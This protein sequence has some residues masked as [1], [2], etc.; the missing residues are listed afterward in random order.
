MRPSPFPPRARRPDS[1]RRSLSDARRDN[2]TSSGMITST[3]SN[4]RFRNKITKAGEVPAF[5]YAFSFRFVNTGPLMRRA[6]W[7]G[8]NLPRLCL[9]I[10]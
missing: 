1:T 8:S 3:K 6:F 5:F 4:Y 7:G 9:N 2:S 10:L